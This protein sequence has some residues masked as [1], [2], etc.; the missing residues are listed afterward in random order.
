MKNTVGGCS[1]SEN[2]AKHTHIID[3]R[4]KAAKERV[5]ETLEKAKTTDKTTRELYAEA[6]AG[7]PEEVVVRM[8]KADTIGKGIR[9]VRN[10]D[11]PKAP[12][13]LAELVLPPIT[14]NSGKC[15][16]CSV[17]V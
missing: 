7:A 11:Y 17:V 14:T 8:P 16:C 4:D 9:N 12:K 3:S 15:C 13:T 6:L 2:A 10:G 5:K 1:Y